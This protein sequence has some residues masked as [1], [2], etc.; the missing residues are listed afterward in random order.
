[1]D[2]LF[3]DSDGDGD[4][5]ENAAD[6]PSQSPPPESYNAD[7]AYSPRILELLALRPKGSG[8]L[9]FHEGVEEG[10]FV[11]AQRE[12]NKHIL[13]FDR[14]P[15]PDA[16]LQYVDDYCYSRHW[17]MHIGDGRKADALEDAIADKLLLHR[18]GDDSRGILVVEMG[19]YC[20]YGAVKILK[21]LSRDDH[22]I[23]IEKDIRC[24]D[25]TNRLVQLCQFAERGNF[26]LLYNNKSSAE[27]LYELMEM[28]L[29]LQKQCVDVLFLDHEKGLY[30]SDLRLFEEAELLTTGS[31]V[32]A[33]NILSF[34]SP[35]SEYLR[36][37]EDRTAYSSSQL[38]AG[39][40]EYCEDMAD[41]KYRDGISISIK[42]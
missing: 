30:L 33:D 13:R 19:S 1:M 3:G 15:D 10:M 31:A 8:V 23:C 40:V 26:S 22:L 4:G 18:G 24:I 12:V 35:L 27:M 36:H 39:F 9:A 2:A 21:N 32:V 6:Y 5:A 11:Y 25:Y 16:I 28:M 17:M 38:V 37:V 14:Y 29:A 20:G 34:N 41:P 42:L 7:G